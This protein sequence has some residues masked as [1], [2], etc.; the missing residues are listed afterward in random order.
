MAYVRLSAGIGAGLMIDGRPFRGAA[1][2]AGEI[3]HVM[4]DRRARSAAAATAAA[5][6]PSSSGPAMCELLRR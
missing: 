5:S 2:V 4:V 1:G 3:G 6:R